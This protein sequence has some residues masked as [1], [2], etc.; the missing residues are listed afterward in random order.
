MLLFIFILRWENWGTEGEEL[1]PHH[2][3]D[4]GRGGTW[5]EILWL[6][7][8]WSLSKQL[9][10]CLETDPMALFRSLILQ[11]DSNM[12]ILNM[13]LERWWGR[14]SRHFPVLLLWKDH[15]EFKMTFLYSG[16]SLV[17]QMVKHLLA[18]QETWDSITGLGR[19]HEKDMATHSNILAWRIPW[20]EEP[21]RLHG[22][23]KNW[24]HTPFVIKLCLGIIPHFIFWPP[25]F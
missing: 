3:A 5:T 9:W 12:L 1:V 8:L 23:T 13:Q 25:I 6:Q 24:T 21:G 18:M 4:R 7:S 10:N 14:G 2:T 11:E 17:A 19:S 16:A 22:V 15:S 20:T